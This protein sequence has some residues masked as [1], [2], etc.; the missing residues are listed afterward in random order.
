M[1]RVLLCCHSTSSFLL[2]LLGQTIA[3]AHNPP[4]LTLHSMQDGHEERVLLLDQIHSSTLH[5]PR[6]TGLWWTQDSRKQTGAPVADI[7]RRNNVIV[8]PCPSVI[9]ISMPTGRLDRFS[10]LHPKDSATT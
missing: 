6:I 10:A 8:V 4:G 9:P 1:V 5:A 3:V 7:F 2:T